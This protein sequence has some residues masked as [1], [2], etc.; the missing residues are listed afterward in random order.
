[1]LR[2][3]HSQNY[4]WLPEQTTCAVPERSRGAATFRNK[5]SVYYSGYAGGNYE[6]LI[7]KC[8]RRAVHDFHEIMPNNSTGKTRGHYALQRGYSNHY[9]AYE[10]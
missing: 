9:R 2:F 10:Y 6:R 5:Q 1:M 7:V 3:T 4:V 8:A